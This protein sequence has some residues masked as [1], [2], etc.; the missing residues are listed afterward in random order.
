MA[1]A[2]TA[3][4]KT[5]TTQSTKSKKAK[6]ESSTPV[7]AT[8]KPRRTPHSTRIEVFCDAGFNNTLFI[9]GEGCSSLSWSAG[10]PLTNVNS[11]CWVWE[12]SQPFSE[13]VQYK[14]LFNDCSYEQGE[15]RKI[16]CG[17]SQSITPRF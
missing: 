9:R 12:S 13:T 11:D 5:T 7:H 15:N 3:A 4:K 10:T 14:I 8:R 17:E 16:E 1:T 6:D 2:A